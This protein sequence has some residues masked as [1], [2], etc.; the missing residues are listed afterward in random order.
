MIEVA[1]FP[2]FVDLKG[3]RCIFIGGGKVATRKIETILEFDPQVRVISPQFTSQLIELSN[4]GKI[5]LDRRHYT[6][7]DIAGAYL[8]FACTSHRNVNE[9]IYL[10]CMEK[11]IHVN[12]ADLGEKCTFTFPS[13]IKRNNF[14]AGISTS[15]SFPVFSK[16]L[17]SKIEEILPYNI[18]EYLKILE[19]YRIRSS[20]MQEEVRRAFLE[21]SCKEAFIYGGS[22]ENFNIH[23]KNMFEV[24]KNGQKI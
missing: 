15:G 6:K 24:Y 23:I 18:D 16:N 9:E 14:V 10:D 21:E 4:E 17:K 5:I 11:G 20:Q 7:G 1:K 2:L 13:I 3:K 22:P 12:V 8:V 19:Y